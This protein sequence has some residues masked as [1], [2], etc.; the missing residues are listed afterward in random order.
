MTASSNCYH[1]HHH[2]KLVF[3]YSDRNLQQIF[4]VPWTGFTLC[5]EKNTHSRFLLYLQFHMENVSIYT[6]FSGYV[7]E[8]IGIPSKSKLNIHCYC[9]LTNILSNVYLLPWFRET[10]YLQTCKH[11]VRI[12]SPLAM[13]I[14]SVEYSIP[15]KHSLEI[16]CKSKHFPRRYKWKREWVYFFW[17]QSICRNNTMDTFCM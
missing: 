16:L 1:H 2:Q 8:E 7:C 3:L 10:Y 15:H 4:A 9:W 14:M 11:D 13:N 17:T 5:S 12:M 6:K